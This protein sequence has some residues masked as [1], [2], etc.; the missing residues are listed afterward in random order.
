MD[1][2]GDPQ[3][4][5][6]DF[7]GISPLSHHHDRSTS[8]TI[9][10]EKTERQ[11]SPSRHPCL[12]EDNAR[13]GAAPVPLGTVSACCCLRV[14]FLLLVLVRMHHFF[15]PPKMQPSAAV[16]WPYLPESSFWYVLPKHLLC[17]RIIGQDKS[18]PHGT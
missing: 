8:R 1:M 15:C 9:P 11:K 18:R 3:G 7:S 5:S 12:S 13:N 10:M 2:R 16:A 4:C 17:I 14:H 6:R